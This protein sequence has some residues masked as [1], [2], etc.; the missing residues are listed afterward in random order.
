VQKGPESI[1]SY[2]IRG[3]LSNCEMGLRVLIVS[4]PV[5]GNIWQ[6]KTYDLELTFVK[7]CSDLWV[8]HQR[9]CKEWQKRVFSRPISNE[10][11]MHGYMVL[12][13]AKCT[14][15]MIAELVV[16]SGLESSLD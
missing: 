11:T 15:I 1:V 9:K 12:T 5:K 13:F 8:I 10:I 3:N 4:Y 7:A 6:I 2:P 16:T 14:T